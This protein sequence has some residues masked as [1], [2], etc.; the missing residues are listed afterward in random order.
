MLTDSPWLSALIWLVLIIELKEP[1]SRGWAR[2][3]N[4]GH[5]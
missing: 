4:F 5:T 1:L 3:S 2:L